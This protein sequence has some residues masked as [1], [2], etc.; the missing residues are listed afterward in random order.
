M[1]D[2]IQRDIQSL[3]KYYIKLLWI[4]D[5]IERNCQNVMVNIAMKI[6]NKAWLK[7]EN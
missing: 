5:K 7:H 6:K 1:P 2:N 4:T 3:Y